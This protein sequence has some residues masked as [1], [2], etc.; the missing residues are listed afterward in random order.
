LQFRR[1]N[2]V[3]TR[4]NEGTRLRTSGK[5]CTVAGSL[6]LASVWG[7]L[8]AQSASA[9]E[10]R[11]SFGIGTG[12]STLDLDGDVGFAT[13]SGGFIG[14]FDIDNGDSAD[15]LKSAFGGGGFANKGRW[16][17]HGLFSTLTLEDDNQ[18]YDVEW[19]QTFGE[20]AVEYMLGNVGNHAFGVIAGVNYTKHEWK[21]TDQATR[22]RIKPDEDWTDAM[23]GVTHR[24][25]FGG[26]WAWANRIDYAG[27]DSEGVFNVTTGVNWN[28]YTHWVF[29]LGL[30]YRDVEYG[31]K[32]DVNDNDF[33]YYDTK[34][35]TINLGFLYIW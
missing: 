8:L 15:M 2:H 12:I 11:W 35:T 32:G 6:F 16:T 25:P 27:G 5:F 17:I 19:D 29:N 1:R 21:F 26:T 30:G 10:D 33:Y 22:E 34:E 18:D 7:L 28:P 31:E 20:L 24:V 23:I 14:D 4:K 9:A 13:G 3:N